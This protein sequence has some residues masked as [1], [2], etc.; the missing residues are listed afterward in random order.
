[1][2]DVFKFKQFEVSQDQC[3][4]KV[5]TD[6]ILLGAWSDLGGKATALDIG[7]GT[8]II[9]LMLAQ[10]NSLLNVHSIEI[11]DKSFRQAKIN[12]T[13]SPFA[14]RMDCIHQSI[15]DY[16]KWTNHKYDL[17]VSNPPFFSGGTFSINENKASVRH[18]L[19]LSH[20]DLLSSVK[21][22]LN[23]GGHFDVILPFIEGLRF[24]EIAAKYDFGAVRM[25]EVN[26]KANKNIE[27]LLIRL[28]QKY[29]GDCD[30]SSLVIYQSDVANDYTDEMI[31]LTKDFYVFMP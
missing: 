10:R 18:T 23:E 16:A 4:M 24:V 17:I 15:Q 28:E 22:L 1:M 5:N 7:T 20:T 31:Q 9:A 25:T 29:K 27:R 2:S 21:I 12:L 14:A 3:T 19:K 8:G 6:G 13:Q 11:E 30:V 26:S